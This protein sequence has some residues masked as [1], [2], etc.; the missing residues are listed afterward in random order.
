MQRLTRAEFETR[1]VCRPPSRDFNGLFGP[2]LHVDCDA[3]ISGVVEGALYV[4][5][6]AHVVVTGIVEGS[7]HVDPEAVLWVQ[8]LVEGPLHVEG[9]ALSNGGCGSVCANRNAIVH[10]PTEPADSEMR[11]AG[12]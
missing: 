5:G 2:E 3:T 8:G 10:D 12:V 11:I 9:A 1:F 7:A 4:H 6:E